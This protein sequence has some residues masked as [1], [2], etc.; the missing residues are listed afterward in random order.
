MNLFKFSKSPVLRA[1]GFFKEKPAP[2]VIK[3]PDKVVIEITN[4]VERILDITKMLVVNWEDK[5]S[6]T[7]LSGEYKRHQVYAK[8]SKI[9]PKVPRA[10][11]GLYIELVVNKLV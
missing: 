6:D 10:K 5:A 11:L 1:L 2:V 9:F 4:E 3:E 8:L 7:V